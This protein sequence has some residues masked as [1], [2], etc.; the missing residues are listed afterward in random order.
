M[1]TLDGSSRRD[2]LRFMA[3]SL[4]LG[5]IGGCA[6]QP[7]ESIVP[8]VQAPESIVPGE[9]MFFATAVPMP[10]GFACGVLVKSQMGRPIKIEGNPD[11]P[12][13]LGAADAFVQ[14]ALL[15]LYDPDRSQMVTH[16]GRVD[17]WEHFQTLALDLRESLRAKK[18]AGLRNPDPDGRPRRHWPTNCDGLEEQFPAAKW[19]S[20]EP[21]SRDAVRAGCRLA[22]GEDLEPVYHLNQADVIVSLDARLLGVGTG[23]AQGCR[24]FAGRRERRRRSGGDLDEPAVR[25]RVHPHA[26]PGP[27]P[28]TGWR[29]RR[30]TSPWSPRAIA[31]ELKIGEPSARL[32]KVPDRLAGHARWIAALARDLA[33][34]SRQELGRCR[35]HAAARSPRPGAFDQPEPRKYRQDDRFPAECDA[36]PGD[37]AGSLGEL[38]R[39]MNAGAVDTLIILGGNP[40]Y[41]APAD[42]EFAR[43]LAGTETKLSIHLGLYDDETAQFCHWHIPEAHALESWSDLRAFDG[44]ATIQQ[45]L[46]APLYNGKSAHELLA[47]LLGEPDLSGLEIVRDYWRRQNLAGDFESAWRTALQ[48]GFIAGTALKP[49]TRDTAR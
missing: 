42:L 2:F 6:Y 40:A 27:R 29:S 20:Y 32:R 43:L 21:V 36:G 31:R 19:H 26:S 45:P 23:P 24:A 3:A 22:F 41:D 47:I 33:A 7:A 1:E 11:H 15:T 46:I 28:I 25:R 49:K 39:D 18:G 30:E 8:Y 16:N 17:T 48:D 9:S 10:D 14:A 13:S 35:R 37:Q 5:G 4:A 38:V 12:A 44:T 34:E